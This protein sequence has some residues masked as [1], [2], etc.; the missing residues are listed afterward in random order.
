MDRCI[1]SRLAP[2]PSRPLSPSP[3]AP[4]PPRHSPLPSS[5]TTTASSHPG[6]AL[7][8]FGVAAVLVG[9]LAAACGDDPT[10]PA[11]TCDGTAAGVYDPTTLAF[12]VNGNLPERDILARIDPALV[13]RLVVDRVG[14]FQLVFLDPETG[15]ATLADGVCRTIEDGIELTFDDPASAQRILLP[16]RLPLE[17]DADAGILSFQGAVSVSRERL[18]ALVPEFA[19][20]PL[21]D[22]VPGRLTVIFTIGDGS[23]GQDS[24]G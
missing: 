22:P 8:G 6:S 18:R 16:S 2:R 15:G 4:P 5:S 7:G 9:A 24:D 17:Y 11:A 1:R 21:S 23:D 3:S 13:P 14:G 12:D 10:E 20:E 19:G